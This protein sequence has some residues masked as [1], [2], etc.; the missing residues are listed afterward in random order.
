MG[1]HEFH[2]MYQWVA[3]ECPVFGG[4]APV[5]AKRLP[6]PFTQLN[7]LHVRKIKTEEKI[8]ISCA[9]IETRQIKFVYRAHQIL[10]KGLFVTRFPARKFVFRS[11]KIMGKSSRV[12]HP[13]KVELKFCV[14]AL[15]M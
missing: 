8:Q 15:T 1:G 14:L 3:L 11:T 4:L 13:T 5:T 12:G 2:Q 9:S 10:L 6:N 7:G